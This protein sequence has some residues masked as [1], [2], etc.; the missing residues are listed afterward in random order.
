MS[1]KA[2]TQA[3]PAFR[4]VGTRRPRPDSEPKVRGRTRFA[5]DRPVHRVLH[6]RLVLAPY[7]HARIE[8]IGRDAARA[9]PGVVAVLTAADLPFASTARDRLAEPLARHE[10]LFAGQPVALVVAETPAEAADAVEAVDVR[11]APEGVVMDPEAA[12]I[13]GGPLVRREVGD[14]GPGP[15]MGAATHAAVGGGGDDAELL[16]ERWSENVTGRY[17]HESG[18]ARAALEAAA[19]TVAT[20]TSTS[21]VHQAHLE[22]QACTAWLDEDDVLVVEASTQGSL[23]LRSDLA[24]V[25]GR[26]VHTIRVVPTTLGGAF[27]AKWG[28]FEPLVAGAA[29]VLRRPVRLTL[30]RRE[31]QTAGNPAPGTRIDVRIG[32]DGEGRFSALEATVVADAGA[33]EEFSAEE[34]AAVLIAGPYAWPSYDIRSY[35]VRTNR[36]GTGA[37]RGPMAPQCAFALETAID[38]LAE[39]LSVD[40]I[41]LR[42]RNLAPEGTPM[43]DGEAWPRTG[44]AEVLDA[45]ADLPAWRGRRSLPRDEGVGVALGCWPGAKDSAAALCRISPDGSIQIVT[46]VVDMSGVAAGFVAIA[47]ETIGLDPRQ[48]E[49]VSIDTAAAPPAPGSG[50][51][52]ITYSVGRAVRDAAEDARRGLIAAAAIQLEIAED[53]LEIVDGAVRPRGTPDRAIPIAEV[54]RAHARAGRAPIVGRGATER[55]S[56]APIL[57]GTIAHVAVDVETGEVRLRSLHL[58]QDVGRALNPALIEAQLV[59]GAVQSIGWGLLEA[60]VH[61]E[62]GQLLS[63]TFLDYALP[64]AEHVPP[65]GMTIVEVPAAD[66]PFGAK[67]VGEG[68]VI[69]GA[70]A[71][72]TAIAAATGVRLHELPMT[73]P[74]V[75]RALGAR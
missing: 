66:G 30:E 13:G 63:A 25:L 36:V 17:R 44:A 40:P 50:G 37:Y 8:V 38:E 6:A 60:L 68:P 21:W 16:A 27:G 70:A 43:V 5:A 49:H 72:A 54:V 62:A 24:N 1:V 73:A 12:M 29:I 20:R 52:V 75:W 15:T 23:S 57:A 33:Y 18:D 10:V 3:T 19:A 9:M 32:A 42:R 67:G 64:R 69:A 34:L 61:D 53:D 58:A 48:V 41:E 2:R 55:P 11:F 56:L 35:G 59:G 74:R 14:D 4:V 28:L 7:A 45:L 47:A 51:S 71:I 39:R 22:T 31:D 26:P 46:G 65:I